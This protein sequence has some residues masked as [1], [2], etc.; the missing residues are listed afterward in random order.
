MSYQESLIVIYVLPGLSFMFYK[1]CLSCLTKI[2]SYVLPGLSLMSHVIKYC[3]FAW[4]MERREA[5][6]AEQNSR[7]SYLKKPCYV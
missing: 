2:V 6:K 5:E 4:S 7:A 3:S 1:D